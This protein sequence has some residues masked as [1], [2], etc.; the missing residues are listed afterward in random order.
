MLRA[1]H[2]LISCEI[3]KKFVLHLFLKINP[4]KNA[5]NLQA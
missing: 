4:A 1:F 5:D 3:K 2:Y